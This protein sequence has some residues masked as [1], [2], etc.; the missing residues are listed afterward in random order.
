MLKRRSFRKDH[1]QNEIQQK[2]AIKLIAP[3]IP[4]TT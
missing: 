1:N 2:G 3:N 4:I